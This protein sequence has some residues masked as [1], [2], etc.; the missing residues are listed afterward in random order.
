LGS[1][2]YSQAYHLNADIDEI[3]V[4]RVPIA[5]RE[6]NSQGKEHFW[7]IKKGIYEHPR[8]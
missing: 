4:M 3:C 5:V 7:K 2:D 1:L 6:Y 8:L